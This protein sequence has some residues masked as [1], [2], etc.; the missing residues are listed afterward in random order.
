V[1]SLVSAVVLAQ[2]AAKA[3]QSLAPQM[4]STLKRGPIQ[5]SEEPSLHTM[6]S[7][8]DETIYENAPVVTEREK[9]VS[10]LCL[11]LVGFATCKVFLLLRKSASN[12]HLGPCRAARSVRAQEAPSHRAPQNSEAQMAVSHLL[13]LEE[14]EEVLLLPLATNR[15]GASSEDKEKLVAAIRAEKVDQ[16]SPSLNQ[17]E[18][19]SSG[20]ELPDVSP[21]GLQD[22]TP[23][24]DPLDSTTNSEFPDLLLCAKFPSLLSSKMPLVKE[25][26]TLPE[27]ALTRRCVRK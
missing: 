6:G 16:S 9:L 2:I 20:L 1:L 7:G 14:M 24:T 17:Q 3:S 4:N 23:N 13:L 8:S 25:I 15:Y 26:N 27:G 18:A 11:C 21:N 22:F 12:H 19:A 10:D 5:L